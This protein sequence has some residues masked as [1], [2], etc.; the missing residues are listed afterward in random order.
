MSSAEVLKNVTEHVCVEWNLGDYLDRNYGCEYPA[1]HTGWGGQDEFVVDCGSTVAEESPV[2]HTVKCSVYFAITL[3]YSCC[4][5]YGAFLTRNGATGLELQTYCLRLGVAMSIVA[6]ISTSD[7][8]AAAGRLPYTLYHVLTS[9]NGA[10]LVIV[11]INCNKVLIDAQRSKG[12]NDKGDMWAHVKRISEV[13]VWIFELVFV[14]VENS[15]E[16]GDGVVNGTLQALRNLCTGLVLLFW[17]VT[18][19]YFTLAIVKKLK[20]SSSKDVASLNAQKHLMRNCY[21]IAFGCFVGVAVKILS[22]MGS[23]G[24]TLY[25]RPSCESDGFF[26]FNHVQLTVL[27]SLVPLICLPKVLK[28]LK[29]KKRA[30]RPSGATTFASDTSASENKSYSRRHSL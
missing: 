19:V 4:N 26:H 3:I 6:L 30:V 23:L 20:R 18:I 16:E 9:M 7:I 29:K 1:I 12:A 27:S 2:D 28:K 21:I 22:F 5:F 10:L 13:T 15:V 17:F 8:D 11:I 14:I 24:K 25:A